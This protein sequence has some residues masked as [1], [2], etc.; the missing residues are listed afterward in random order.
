MGEGIFTWVSVCDN[1]SSFW[2]RSHFCWLSTLAANLALIAFVCIFW[3]NEKSYNF[4]IITHKYHMLYFTICV[5]ICMY[6]CQI[7]NAYNSYIPPLPRNLGCDECLLFPFETAFM[8][9]LTDGVCSIAFAHPLW[10]S[11]ILKSHATGHI[12]KF[13]IISAN[14]SDEAIERELDFLEISFMIR[15]EVPKKETKISRILCFFPP[16]LY[17]EMSKIKLLLYT[18]IFFC[19]SLPPPTYTSSTISVTGKKQYWGGKD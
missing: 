10:T 15:T 5:D 6:F 8:L 19:R 18:D 17:L 7:C 2:K 12:S 13:Y 16:I 1:E 9:F 4:Y 14:F 3:F 11:I